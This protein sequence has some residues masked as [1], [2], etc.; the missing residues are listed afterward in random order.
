MSM[1]D[2]NVGFD[3]YK[4]YTS[5]LK[6]SAN[7]KTEEKVQSEIPAKDSVITSA[8]T[9]SALA[10]KSAVES[11]QKEL[12]VVDIN[13]VSESLKGI[14]DFSFVGRDSDVNKLDATK[15]VSDMQKDDVLQQYQY[16]VG[17]AQTDDVEGAV[18][19]K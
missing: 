19:L 15:A 3:P 14:Q 9:N 2:L 8:G 16:F 18:L 13:E 1:V 11:L 10:S 12:P 7:I 6:K 4:D 17:S 5:I